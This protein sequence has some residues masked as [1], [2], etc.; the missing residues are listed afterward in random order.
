MAPDIFIHKRGIVMHVILGAGGVI[1]N[2]LARNLYGL[3][4]RIRLVSRH[5]RPVN[6]NDQV[7]AAD[8]THADQVF[9]AVRGANVAYLTAGLPYKISVWR[10]FWPAIMSNVI[11]AC[12]R[13]RVK[14]V[15]FDNVYAYGR[16][17]GW[18]TETCPLSP[19][20]E[21]GKVRAQIARMLMD[22]VDKGSLDAMIV[23]AADF[24]GPGAELAFVH[25]LVFEKLKNGKTASWIA[26]AHV[27]HSLTYTPDAGKATA[28]LG[29]TD[30]AYNQVWHLPTHRD[31]PTGKAFIEKVAAAFGT[32]PKYSVLKKWMLIMAGPF[33]SIARES[34][35]MTYQNEQ[36]YLF[37]SSKFEK[38]FFPATPYDAG[39][40]ETVGSMRKRV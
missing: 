39:I 15:F 20:S 8:L 17:D 10:R 32:R 40:R 4:D 13:H 5:P 16:V 38:R 2:E 30:D 22:A 3:T 9:E 31:A 6:T 14:L 1:G 23:R 18:M 19:V 7:F 12:K 27:P 34:I 35:E 37:D 33:N 28:L 24:Y 26:N 21:K 36:D 29:N 25:P 11:E